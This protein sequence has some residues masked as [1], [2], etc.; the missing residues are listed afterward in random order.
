MQMTA[1]RATTSAYDID[2]PTRSIQAT[3]RQTER[4]SAVNDSET[5]PVGR[6]GRVGTVT[7]NRTKTLNA[8]NSPMLADIITAL[9]G[10]ENDPGIGAIILTGSERAFAAG[11]DI[12]EMWPQSYAH[13]FAGDFLAGWE[14]PAAVR[15]PTIAAVAGCAHR[16]G[17]EVAMMCD[18]VIAAD[19]EI[20][21]TRDH[22]GGI[23]GLGGSQ[24]HTHATG[25]AKAMDLLL[26]GRTMDAAEAERAGLI[27]RIIPA[28]Q[29][30]GQA[31]SI[32][33]TI[34]SMSRPVAMMAKEAVKRSFETTLGE[35]CAT[36]GGLS[37]R[38]S[39]STIRRKACPR[40]SRSA[41][42]PSPTTEWMSMS[43]P[44]DVRHLH[45]ATLV[46]ASHCVPPPRCRHHRVHATP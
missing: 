43:G 9:D 28:D 14:R 35:D 36:S 7:L 10:L 3:I 42:R 23:P 38:R 24:R 37:T 33:E 25:K 40:S 4:K 2:I 21:P 32:A 29:L 22:S 13:V 34:A 1:G 20:R 45:S 27:G 12:K 15:K 8:P 16:G 11:A 44:S 17:R 19:R 46:H 31:Q 6:K 26:A 18:L 39:H 30:L 41:T 5:I